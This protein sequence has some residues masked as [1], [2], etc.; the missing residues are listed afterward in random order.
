MESTDELTNMFEDICVLYKDLQ[1]EPTQILNEP[2]QILNEPNQILNEPN[3]ILNEPNQAASKVVKDMEKF[4]TNVPQS[5][6]GMYTKMRYDYAGYRV[7]RNIENFYSGLYDVYY[8]FL[9]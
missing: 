3:Q 7:S 1:N 8:T 5:K 9:L 4:F 6:K 2:N